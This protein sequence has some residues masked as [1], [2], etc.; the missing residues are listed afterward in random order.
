MLR[1][2][3]S[4]KVSYFKNTDTVEKNLNKAKKLF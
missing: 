2:S 1:A 3:R 4:E